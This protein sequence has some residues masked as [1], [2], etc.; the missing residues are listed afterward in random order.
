MNSTASA[1]LCAGAGVSGAV[2]PRATQSFVTL[3]TSAPDSSRTGSVAV[4][5]TRTALTRM[6]CGRTSAASVREKVSSPPLV[7]A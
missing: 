3:A 6:P 5:P 1:T 7:A 2:P 4:G